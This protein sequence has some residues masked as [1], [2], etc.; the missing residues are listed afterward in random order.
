MKTD[1]KTQLKQYGVAAV[2]CV[3]LLAVGNVLAADDGIT[4]AA[5]GTKTWITDTF[6]PAIGIIGGVALTTSAIIGGYK[7]LKRLF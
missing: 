3:G 1:V 5:T 4:A 6:M 7:H 2:A